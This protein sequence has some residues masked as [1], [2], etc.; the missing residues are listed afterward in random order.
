MLKQGTM[1]DKISALSAIVQRNP[2]C[3]VSYLTTLVGMAKKK[4]RKMAEIAINA[5]KDLFTNQLLYDDQIL[6]PFSKHPKLQKKNN[7]A[8]ADLIEAFF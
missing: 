4:N 5:V 1:S 7:P 8:P 2:E 3:S 6:T